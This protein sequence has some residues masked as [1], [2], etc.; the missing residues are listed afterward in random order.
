MPSR[1][2]GHL[3]PSVCVPQFGS[4]VMNACGDSSEVGGINSLRKPKSKGEAEPKQ[5]WGRLVS[6]G[7]P[8]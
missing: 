7:R 5:K 8:T 6:M 1:R 3:L 2:G 4:S